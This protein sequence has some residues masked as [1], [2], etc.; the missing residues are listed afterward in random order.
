M[1]ATLLNLLVLIIGMCATAMIG[2]L[3]ARERYRGQ[4]HHQ[5]H[6]LG[7][8]IKRMRRRT[9]DAEN[10][11]MKLKREQVRAHRVGKVRGR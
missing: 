7:G 10:A 6:V 8:E 5:L 11:A 3:F 2:Y 4:A 1:S 9:R